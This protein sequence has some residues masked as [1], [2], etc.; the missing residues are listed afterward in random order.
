MAV[1]QFKNLMILTSALL[2]TACSSSS[3][4]PDE[5]KLS[6]FQIIGVD[7]TSSE[8]LPLARTYPLE[9]RQT[10]PFEQRNTAQIYRVDP[11]QVINTI[12][13]N[14][15]RLLGI[16]YVWGATG[17]YTYDC[18]G[19]TQK[20]YGSSGI[21]LPRVSRDQ[22]RVGQFVKYENLRRGDMVFFDTKKKRTGI[23]SHVGIYL[24]GGN[25]IHASSAAKKV[26]IYNFNEKS[27]Y[28]KRFLWG[29]R[30]VKDNYFMASL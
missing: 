27:F 29:R 6:S 11:T 17:P 30:V 18:S 14:A 1:F 8:A 10:A 13:E 16:K 21:F 4:K 3:P 19:F 9:E 26:V 23:V 25:F 2:F 20:I 24:G 12:E 22:A 15:K 5:S 28:K 7:T